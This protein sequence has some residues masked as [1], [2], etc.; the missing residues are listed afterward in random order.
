[1]LLAFQSF[2]DHCGQTTSSQT[3]AGTTWCGGKMIRLLPLLPTPGSA[4]SAS[5]LPHWTLSHST[6]N[7]L[8]HPSFSSQCFLVASLLNSLPLSP[9]LWTYSTPSLSPLL[10]SLTTLIH[11]FSRALFPLLSCLVTRLHLSLGLPPM[12]ALCPNSSAIHFKSIHHSHTG[13]HTCP[14]L[15]VTG[16]IRHRSKN[17][18]A[19]D[20]VSIYLTLYAWAEPVHPVHMHVPYVTFRAADSSMLW[21]C[22][23]NPVSVVHIH[24]RGRGPMFSALGYLCNPRVEYMIRMESYSSQPQSKNLVE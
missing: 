1:M 20:N 5:H 10:P 15:W 13:H 24:R 3:L 21:C 16:C 22:R 8:S 7:M 14:H 23:L 9:P 6:I 18:W 17:V 19:F 4:I 2:V 11:L 12:L